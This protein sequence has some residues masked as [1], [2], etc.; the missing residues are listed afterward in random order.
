MDIANHQRPKGHYATFYGCYLLRSSVSTGSFYIGSTPHP[1]RRLRQH[2]RELRTGGAHRTRHQRLRP[3]DMIALVSGFPS[4]SAALMFEHALQ[5]AHQCRHIPPSK[6]VLG[7]GSLNKHLANIKL[8][9]NSRFFS[10]LPLTLTF[11]DYMVYHQW[12]LDKLGVGNLNPTVELKLDLEQPDGEPTENSTGQTAA[13]AA[14]DEEKVDPEADK[15]TPFEPLAQTTVADSNQRLIQHRIGSNTL[16]ISLEPYRPLLAKSLQLLASPQL[17]CSIT[18]APIPSS[19]LLSV[20]LAICSH[21]ACEFISPLAVLAKHFLEL[22]NAKL[23]T[24]SSPI[25]IELPTNPGVFYTS[26]IRLDPV[27]PLHGPCP[28]CGVSLR[29]AQLARNATLIMDHYQGVT[30]E[31]ENESSEITESSEGDD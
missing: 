1:Y 10:R 5:H 2:N 28:K 16:D 8:L 7:G 18:Q 17:Y 21:S 29:W 11:F 27:I 14:T 15:E 19:S 4:S 30:L 3:W 24:A 26:N 12:S 9:L 25:Q 31:D 23:P 20:P 22:E 13:I 6:R